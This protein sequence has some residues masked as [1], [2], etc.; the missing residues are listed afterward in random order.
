[1]NGVW[2]LAPCCHGPR[3]HQIRSRYVREDPP[4]KA[5]DAIVISGDII[6]GVPSFAIWPKATYSRSYR[7][8]AFRQDLNSAL[9]VAESTGGVAQQL[10]PPRAY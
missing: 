10:P 9:P 1:M 3:P 7:G 6:Q 2:R 5:P 4:I 8:P